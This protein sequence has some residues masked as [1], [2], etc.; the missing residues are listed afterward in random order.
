[1]NQPSPVQKGNGEVQSLEADSPRDFVFWA[2]EFDEVANQLYTSKSGLSAQ[3]A[4]KRLMKYGK[5]VP[6]AKKSQNSIRLLMSQFKSPIVIIFI[7]TA[8]VSYFLEGAHDS[9]IIL[10]IVFLSAGLGFWQERGATKAIERL[11]AMVK[12][13]AIV[14][15]DKKESEVFAE[16]LVPGDI[17]LLS[18][19]DRIPAD[20]MIV[21][22]KD[23]FA[24]ESFLT[25]ESYPVEKMP[26]GHALS[27]DTPVSKRT[28]SLLMGSFV[29]SG[30][31]TAIVARTGTKTELGKISSSIR[32]RRPETDFERGVRHFGYFLVEVTLILVVANFGINVYLQR[33]VIDSFLFSLALAIGLTPQLLPAII[34]VNLAHGAKRM[35]SKKV[36]VRRLESIENAG[37]MNILCSDKTGTLTTGTIEIN[38]IVNANGQ[39]DD[40]ILLYA[41][42]NAANETGYVNPIDKAITRMGESRGL[43]I[44]AY[45]K[46]DEIPFDFV[47]KR[48][49]ILVRPKNSP[50][51]SPEL[52]EKSLL[53]TKGAVDAVLAICSEVEDAPRKISV[54]DSDHRKRIESLF[55]QMSRQGFRILAVAYHLFPAETTRIT[56]EHEEGCTFV[57][58]LALWDP[59]K[60]DAKQSIS[61]LESLGISL[62]MISG[63]NKLIAGHV[64]E[65]VGLSSAR[66]MTGPELDGMSPEALEQRVRKIDIFAE[67]VPRQKERIILALK[68][69]GNVVGYMG[70]GI[71]DAPALHASDIGIS[72]DTAT[73]VVKE[74]ADLVLLEK[75]LRVLADGV[76]EGR[77]TFANT[78]KYVFMAT[79]SN[80]GNMFS[81]AVASFLLP[82]LPMLPKQ[83]LLN[84]LLTDLQETTIASDNVDRG[85]LAG[86]RRWDMRLIRRFM[87]VFGPLS[88]AFDFAMFGIL[89]L[90]LHATIDQFRTAWFIESVLSAALVVLAIRSRRPV[91][92]GRPGRYLFMATCIVAAAAAVIPLTPLGAVFGLAVLPLHYYAWIAAIVTSYIVAVEAA[93]RLFYRKGA[94]RLHL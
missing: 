60:D 49:S 29:A 89:I 53:I 13:K 46:L 90:L 28:N 34:A 30:R 52:N 14:L 79:S 57:G 51:P 80:F 54:L 41:Y 72:V 9:T 1:M 35:A 40:R 93:K 45:E 12:T 26:E 43:D 65:K 68:K 16:D 44:S 11:L 73:D 5:N 8:I 77:R 42:L 33:P 31:A 69:S 92:K 22:S 64:G 15:R 37:S 50:D 4:R 61:A 66:M 23:L 21:E 83:I 2:M 91:L 18:A 59:V 38:S 6:T 87:I 39:K 25:G 88:A 3:D 19:G 78:L 70:D 74:E 56:R 27:I 55:E 85:L 75:N 82:F 20:C 48:L 58:F 36:I 7:A 24:N 67:I 76:R 10:F 17:V 62:K 86:P 32:P 63:D 47:R 94:F 71:N 84:N 81:T